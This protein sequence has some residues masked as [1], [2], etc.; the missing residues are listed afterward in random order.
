MDYEFS[1][2]GWHWAAREF[3]D[4]LEG[5]SSYPLAYLYATWLGL[6]GHMIG[7]KV[8]M[9]FP[10]QLFPNM[11]ICLV[12]PSAQGR[13]STA[14]HLAHAAIKDLTVMSPPLRTVTTQQGLLQAMNDQG[15]HSLVLL[16]ELSSMTSKSRMDYGSDLLN[17]ITELYDVPD[18]ASTH[19][20]KDPIT[21]YEPFLSILSASTIEWIQSTVSMTD[22]MGGLGNRMTFIPGDE[23]P[24]QPWPGRPHYTLDWTITHIMEGELVPTDECKDLWVQWYTA[25]DERQR[26]TSPFLRTMAQRI[27][28]KAWKAALIMSVWNGESYITDASLEMAL[29]WSDY[30]MDGLR[31]LVPNFE[32]HEKQIYTAIQEGHDNRRSLYAVLRNRMTP[33]QLQNS[34]K[35]LEWMGAITGDDEYYATM[36]TSLDEL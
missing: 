4:G 19:T 14:L 17:R 29:D 34:L 23:R 36:V 5:A 18:T 35:T 31:R 1:R 6:S 21:V 32:D 22:L 24:L 20:R 30:L 7:R 12:G 27:P 2:P 9:Y 13:K 8:W 16:D 28:E 25:F 33:R 3:A 15:G 11:Y 10:R 26:R